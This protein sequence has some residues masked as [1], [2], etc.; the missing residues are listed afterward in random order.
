VPQ[1]FGR[2]GRNG[3][4]LAQSLINETQGYRR[5][6]IAGSTLDF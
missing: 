5:H 4:C 6:N 1:S 3:T 2:T